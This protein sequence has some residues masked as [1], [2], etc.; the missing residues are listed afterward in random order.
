MCLSDDLGVRE[1]GTRRLVRGLGQHV[2]DAGLVRHMAP[3][4]GPRVPLSLRADRATSM[5]AEALAAGSS[6][7]AASMSCTRTPRAA[8]LW[9]VRRLSRKNVCSDQRLATTERGMTLPAQRASCHTW[10]YTSSIFLLA[11]DT[12]G[13]LGETPFT[14]GT[15]LLTSC[16][17]TGALPRCAFSSNTCAD[18]V[19]SLTVT[20]PRSPQVCFAN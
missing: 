13:R 6:A 8:P 11:M 2:E 15:V 19:V 5:P 17:S 20:V 4:V 1:G 3:V 9:V 10:R 14:R 12:R 16:P 7:D 18:H